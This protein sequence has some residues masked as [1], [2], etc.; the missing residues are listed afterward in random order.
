MFVDRNGYRRMCHC[1]AVLAITWRH[2]AS[3]PLMLA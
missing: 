1:L 3:G 2:A